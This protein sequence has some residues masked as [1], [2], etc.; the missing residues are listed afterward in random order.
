MITVP[1]KGFRCPPELTCQSLFQIVGRRL[2]R[3]APPTFPAWLPRWDYDHI[4]T[5]GELSAT[6]Y[7]CE[8]A[9]FSDHRAVSARVRV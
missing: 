3:P 9:I 7:Q 2:R 1:V 6:H 5:G 4:V 8:V